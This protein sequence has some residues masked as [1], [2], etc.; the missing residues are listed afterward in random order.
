MLRERL[1]KLSS[2]LAVIHVGAATGPELREK[3]RRTEG[4]WQRRGRL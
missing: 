2:S 3:L 4:L 1:A